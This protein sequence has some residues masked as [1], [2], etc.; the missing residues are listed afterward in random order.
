LASLTNLYNL[1]ADTGN[2]YLNACTKEQGH[3]MCRMEFGQEFQGQI[4]QLSDV[5]CKFEI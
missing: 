4:L 5:H 1:S 3:T 2:V